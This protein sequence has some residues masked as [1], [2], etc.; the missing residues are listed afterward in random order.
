MT[1]ADGTPASGPA[2]LVVDDDE[3][4]RDLLTRRLTRA[5]FPEA[6]TAADGLE[7]LALLQA[8]AFDLVMLDVMMPKMDGVSVLR[9]MKQDPVL[10]DVPV[11]MISAVDDVASVAECIKL[12][13]EDFLPKP[14]DEVLLR[15][16]LH[17]S[18]ERKR[19]RDREKH[20]MAALAEALADVKKARELSDGLLNNILPKAVADELRE[21]NA[22]EPMYF[23]DATIIFTDFV[24]FTVSTERLSADELVQLLHSYFTG[25][26][27]IAERYGIEKLK[28]IGDSYMCAGGLP[29]RNPAHPVDA[30]LAAFDMLDFVTAKR[31]SGTGADW[32][33]RIGVH[34]GPVIA[35][36]VGLHK[37]AFDIWGESVNIASRMESTG[38]PDRISLSERTYAR[39][40]DFFKCEH[41]G[42]VVTK[43]GYQLDAYLA[44]GVQPGLLD[45]AGDPTAGFS[46]RYQKYFGRAIPGLPCSL[47]RPLAP[48]TETQA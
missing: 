7:A 34:T 26:D 13:A 36:V 20:N 46:R 28:T 31:T 27:L 23:G 43:E 1:P 33:V 42:K 14:F 22:V 47:I 6:V 19:L 45:V 5:G 48:A 17:G 12:G 30:V 29:E 9:T 16:R 40:K 8:T 39:V 10:C 41:R 15:A 11:I 25:M 2:L 21:K 38:L 4:N 24:G 18:L 32:R 3:N 37:F 35:G 44:D